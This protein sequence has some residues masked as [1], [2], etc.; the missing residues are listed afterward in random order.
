MPRPRTS[1]LP[2]WRR[3]RFILVG[4]VSLIAC[5][6]LFKPSL[7]F[8]L[9]KPQPCAPLQ[10]VELAK[11]V[12]PLPQAPLP[13]I[14]TL[15]GALGKQE[16]EEIRLYWG[17]ALP[18][19]TRILS[20]SPG[21]TVFENLYMMNGTTFVVTISPEEVPDLRYVL[22][23]GADNPG[24]LDPVQDPTDKDMQV[25]T[26]KQAR[27]WFGASAVNLQGNTLWA[28]ESAQMLPHYYHFCA[29]LFFGI[30]R[31]YTSLAPSISDDGQTTLPL[32]RRWIFPHVDTNGWRDYAR[33]NQY[34]L[35]SAMPSI[36]LLFKAGFQ[37]FAEFE[38]PFV[39]ERVVM[40]DRG[41][42][43]RGSGWMPAQRLASQAFEHRHVDNWWEPI[44]RNVVRFATND[45]DQRVA[46]PTLP[47]PAVLGRK[48]KPKEEKPVITY[49]S[50]QNW[51]T[52]SLR[53]EDHETLVKALYRLRDTYG[54]EVNVVTMD[55]LTRSEQIA[56]AARTTILIGPHGNGLT[57]LLWMKPTPRSAV[58][59]FFFPT[60]WAYD[61]EWTA[62]HLGI[63]HYG[64]HFDTYD[65]YPNIPPAN[66]YPP[67]YQGTDMPI[68]GEAVAR[69]IQKRL[70]GQTE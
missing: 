50:R 33:M 45:G 51:N 53:A 15:Q 6:L 42:A 1:F 54:Y 7:L 26:P 10:P 55:T 34:V 19:E 36:Q 29:E 9:P 14:T 49:V 64:W 13:P 63:K 70:S 46:V 59:E 32:P 47:G 28:H 69:E 62:R 3:E 48:T 23:S 37:D 44:R 18:P 40:C 56:L 12:D 21:F 39:L 68:D 24:Y 60:G 58:M 57:A 30:W 38:R 65:Q 17:T 66:H 2:S 20:H 41:A 11:P 67:G 31:A 4:V 8:S 5:V 25:I 27:E 16:P 61:Y 43:I 35:F 52:R 22:G